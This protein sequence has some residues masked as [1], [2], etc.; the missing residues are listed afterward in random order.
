M[1][2]RPEAITRDHMLSILSDEEAAGV[3]LWETAAALV[4][5]DEFVDLSDLDK[6][7]QRVAEARP[8][9]NV[10]SR[11]A[12]NEHTWKKFIANLNARNLMA[13]PHQ[14][15]APVKRGD[16]SRSAA[17]DEADSSK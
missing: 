15:A 13:Q 6:G 2:K 12:I 9:G 16:R 1:K 5:G 10:V 14:P 3:D 8:T 7:V 4:A 17:H 11:K